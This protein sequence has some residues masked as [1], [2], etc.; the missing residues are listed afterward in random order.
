MIARE[1]VSGASGTH[2][3]HRNKRRGLVPADVVERRGV[4]HIAVEPPYATDDGIAQ[5]CRGPGNR[6]ENRLDIGRRS[7]DHPQDLAHRRL[8]FQRFSQALPRSRT[9]APTSCGDLRV[10][11]RVALVPAFAP[12]ARRLISSF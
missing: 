5:P 3:E 11:G 8:L 1:N 12:F 2:R 7:A 4:E 9:L 10:D 6:I